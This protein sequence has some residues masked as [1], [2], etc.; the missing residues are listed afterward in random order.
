ME[1]LDIERMKKLKNILLLTHGDAAIGLLDSAGMLVGDV[2]GLFALTLQPG[3]SME[4][5]MAM[6]E[7]KLEEL[8]DRPLL[9]VDLIGGTPSN[10]SCMLSKDHDFD[11]IGGLN[12][13]MLLEA[14]M[15][16]DI[17][18][19]DEYIAAVEAAGREGCKN[20]LAMLDE[21]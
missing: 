7:E 16:R 6:V 8:G 1:I 2:P 11:V 13:A 3:V 19:E 18:P 5:Y 17:L 9:L 20:V 14:C 12:L 15:S 4:E 21:M 10:V